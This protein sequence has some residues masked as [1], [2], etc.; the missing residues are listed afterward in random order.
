[1]HSLEAAPIINITKA[2]SQQMLVQV[3]MAEACHLLRRTLTFL[4]AAG[5]A[6]LVPA[7]KPLGPDWKDP[8]NAGAGAVGA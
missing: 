2:R 6:L 5:A 4:L 1:M 3:V 8:L 7:A